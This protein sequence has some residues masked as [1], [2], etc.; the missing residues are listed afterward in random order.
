MNTDMPQG[1]ENDNLFYDI[2]VLLCMSSYYEIDIR[3][4]VIYLLLQVSV[5]YASYVLRFSR[6]NRYNLMLAML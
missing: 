4:N 6:I 2:C 1:Y 3:I 5:P